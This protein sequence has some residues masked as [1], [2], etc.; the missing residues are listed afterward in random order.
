MERILS[1]GEVRL[2]RSD[3]DV[4]ETSVV[5][6]PYANLPCVAAGCVA[7]CYRRMSQQD[8]ARGCH[9]KMPQ[10]DVTASCHSRMSQQDV[11]ARCH[12]S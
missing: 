2:L 6:V 12:R 1:R 3:V 9:K 4:D 11:T 5:E 10:Q 7:G 8:A